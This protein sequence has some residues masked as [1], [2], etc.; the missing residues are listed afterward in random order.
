[1]VFLRLLLALAVLVIRQLLH[2]HK[3]IMEVQA[4]HL[5]QIMAAEVVEV[6]L[7]RLAHHLEAQEGMVVMEP[8]QRYRA[9]Q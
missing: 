1:M 2:R 6:L 7:L 3:E 4:Q 5:P 9:H 8:H